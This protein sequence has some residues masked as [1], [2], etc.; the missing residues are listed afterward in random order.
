MLERLCFKTQC[1]T[2]LVMEFL[3]LTPA[4]LADSIL[5]R[6]TEYKMRERLRKKRELGFSGW[7]TPQIENGDLLLR[8]KKSLNKG[9]YIDVINFAAMLLAMDGMFVEK[10]LKKSE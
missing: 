1:D 2:D 3:N 8:L 10:H 6:S 4:D 5:V 9:A 7:N